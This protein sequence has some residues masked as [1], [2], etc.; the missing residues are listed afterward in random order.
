MLTDIV[1]MKTRL[2]ALALFAVVGC[3]S[4]DGG[5]PASDSQDQTSAGKTLIRVPLVATSGTKHPKRVLMSSFNDKLVAGGFKKIPDFIDIDGRPSAKTWFDNAIAFDDETT[6]LKIDAE[7]EG[8]AGPE[9]F[10]AHSKTV[11]AICYLGDAHKVPDMLLQATDEGPF[12]EQLG[13]HAWRFKK[14]VHAVDSDP[15]KDFGPDGNLG[16][17]PEVWKG[18]RGEGEAILVLTHEGDDGDDV[19]TSVISKCR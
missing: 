14:E 11:P 4:K 12:S 2:L 1:S 5:A 9:N 16:E 18:W 15:D 3:S 19:E 6:K 13:I 17:L 10:T 8:S 7:Q